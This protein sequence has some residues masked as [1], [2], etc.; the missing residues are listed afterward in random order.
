MKRQI[1]VSF[2]AVFILVCAASAS[3]GD[4]PKSFLWKLVTPTNTV[5]LLGSIHVANPSL[6]PLSPVI[7]NA[8][9]DSQKL[10]VEADVSKPLDADL[11]KLMGELS[12]YDTGQTLA[13]ELP[14]DIYTDLVAALKLVKLEEAHVKDVRPWSVSITLMTRYLGQL[15][16]LPRYGIDL[17]FLQK[18][19]QQNKPILEL[20][21]AEEQL[22][23]LGS[24]NDK[25]Q[26]QFLRYTLIDLHNADAI[27]S[28][29]LRAWELGD[30]QAMARFVF[31][32]KDGD[33]A[34]TKILDIMFY[35]RNR[36]MADKILSYLGDDKN[37]FVV[38]GAGHL[39]GE[40]SILTLLQRRGYR[41]FQ[42]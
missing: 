12:R 27:V 10:V 37:Y 19:V 39:V 36:R 40:Q 9:A 18:A 3:S 29:M 24:L 22:R 42:M 1:I 14:Q 8:Y 32:L 35:Q 25:Q 20:E 28:D 4:T 13:S 33:P 11:S 5:Y 15:G 16:I 26:A 23:M 30:T 6:Y 34:M 17:H 31:D 7:E 41:A 38:V 2:F 21:S